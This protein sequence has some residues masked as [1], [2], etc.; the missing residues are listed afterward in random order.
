[1]VEEIEQS[2]LALPGVQRAAVLLMTLGEQHAAEILRHLE[3][4]EV[5]K[6]GAAMASIKSVRH[7]QIESVLVDFCEVA[8]TETSIGIAS[9]DFVRNVLVRALGREKAGSLMDRI[10]EG[11]SAQGVSPRAASA[12][13]PSHRSGSAQRASASGRHRALLPRN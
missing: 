13:Q 9:H 8:K 12:K 11:D 5:Q 1:M 3:P 4:R 10:L 7:E 2:Q 6:I